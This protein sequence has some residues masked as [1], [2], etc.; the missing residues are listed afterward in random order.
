MRPSRLG[1]V[2]VLATLT[3]LAS[4]AGCAR[5]SGQPVD[6]GGFAA[7]GPV[8]SGNPDDALAAWKDFPVDRH[9]RP[10][11][12]IGPSLVTYAG[13]TTG[14]A[15]AAATTGDYR[16][17]A[18]LP[19]APSTAP[20]TLPDGPATLPVIGAAAAIDRLKADTGDAAKEPG[21]PPLAI[22]SVEFG[23]AGFDTDR[24]TLMLPVWRVHTADELGPTVVL[25]V[26]D[27][28]LA[29]RSSGTGGMPGDTG[30]A[31]LSADGRRLTVTVN[32]VVPHCPGEPIYQRTAAV[33]ETRSTV[34]VTFTATQTGTVP[35]GTGG[36]CADYLKLQPATY[37]VGLASPLGGRVLVDAAANPVPVTTG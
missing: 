8:P 17:D 22:T 36:A 7:P 26:A 4:A 5:G 31:K 11:V 34:V 27:P 6:G 18:T 9:P 35:G 13:Y 14:D 1:A 25:A 33:R 2:A 30:T 19:P 15:K 21:V 37:Q 10:I 3:L 32:E 20:V 23:T 12:L 28:A 16:L 24:G 29:R